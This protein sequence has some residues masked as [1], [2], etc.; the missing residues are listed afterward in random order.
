MYFSGLLLPFGIH[1]IACF[2][3]FQEGFPLIVS[4]SLYVPLMFPY[5]CSTTF[6]KTTVMISQTGDTEKLIFHFG[7]DFISIKKSKQ[8]QNF[9]LRNQNGELK[10]QNLIVKNQNYGPVKSLSFD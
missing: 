1:Q 4:D 8:N 10:N 6:F 2:F 9:V 3:D 7:F 5:I